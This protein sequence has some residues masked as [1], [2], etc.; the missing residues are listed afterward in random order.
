MRDP[1]DI[2]A[3]IGDATTS[4]WGWTLAC[5]ICWNLAF[6][7]A[8]M[9]TGSVSLTHIG[10]A[11]FLGFL[12]LVI[13]PILLLLGATQMGLCALA[14]G[15]CWMIAAYADWRI[16]RLVSLIVILAM[17][18]SSGHALGQFKP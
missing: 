13:S 18:A 11:A 17:G 14:A 6:T 8:L 12:A 5:T 4:F 1:G 15:L 10:L 3:Q 7:I 16:G 2:F 9:T